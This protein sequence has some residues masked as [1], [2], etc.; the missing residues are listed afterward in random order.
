MEAGVPGPPQEPG[1][2]AP[3][4]K[5]PAVPGAGGPAEAA[6]AALSRAPSPGGRLPSLDHRSRSTSCYRK[7]AHRAA[8]EPAPRPGR[9]RRANLAGGAHATPRFPSPSR[10]SAVSLWASSPS[11]PA[12]GRGARAGPLQARPA[13]HKAPRAEKARDG[14]TRSAPREAAASRAPHGPAPRPAPRP[15]HRSAPGRAAPPPPPGR[16]PPPAAPASPRARR[17]ARPAALRPGSAAGAPPSLAPSP[18]PSPASPS[19]PPPPPPA[20]RRLPGARFGAPC[21]QPQHRRAGAGREE[22][23]VQGRGRRCREGARRRPHLRGLHA[24]RRAG[25]RAGSRCG[26]RAVGVLRGPRGSQAASSAA[27]APGLYCA[28]GRA[29][30]SRGAAASRRPASCAPTPTFPPSCGS[31]IFS[32]SRTCTSRPHTWRRRTCRRAGADGRTKSRP[33]LFRA[34]ALRAAASRRP[35]SSGLEERGCSR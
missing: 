15:S 26:R 20:P 28:A 35:G 1:P 31:S 11:G 12:E 16:R 7:R 3:L 32:W 8:S 19:S 23:A 18:T 34:V 13:A 2:V 22:A 24:E 17:P 5:A 6:E 9:A 25:G 4:R 33:A 29:V 14:H 30:R 10:P 27:P 21:L